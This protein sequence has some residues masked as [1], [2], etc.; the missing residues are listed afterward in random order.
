MAAMQFTFPCRLW[1]DEDGTWQARFRDLPD[2]M[3]D[4][5]DEA[6]ALAEAT[7]CLAA[8]LLSRLRHGEPLPAP[9]PAKSGEQLVSP[10]PAV[11]LK[12]ALNQAMQR[13]AV[14]PAE[15]ARRLGTDHKS[16]RRL[17]DLGHPSKLPRLT[18]ALAALGYGIQVEVCDVL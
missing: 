17:L 16:A 15:L 9:S 5:G 12:L 7:D 6:E 18:A 8:A 13:R 10:Q 1:Q 11:L 3:T 4:G 14:T 2:A